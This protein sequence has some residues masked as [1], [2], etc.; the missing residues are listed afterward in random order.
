MFISL[1]NNALSHFWV[2]YF[3]VVIK[4]AHTITQF[5]FLVY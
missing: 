2:V 3:W 5:I 1:I 4:N